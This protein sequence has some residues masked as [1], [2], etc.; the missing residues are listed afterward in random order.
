MPLQSTFGGGAA[1]IYRGSRFGNANLTINYSS[2]AGGGGGSFTGYGIVGYGAGGAGGLIQ[3]T[4]ITIRSFIYVII[5]AGG[6]Q[7]ASGSNTLMYNGY[8]FYVLAKGGGGANG[9][10][11]GSGGGAGGYSGATPGL[12]T[13]GQGNNG[14]ALAGTNPEYGGSG[15]GGAGAVGGTATSGSTSSGGA[16]GNGLACSATDNIVRAGG[17]GGWSWNSGTNLFTKANGGTGGG[18]NGGYDSINPLIP[19][20]NGATNTGGGGGG[21]VT[22]NPGGSGGSGIVVIRYTSA[23]VLARGGTITQSGGNVFHTFTSSGVFSTIS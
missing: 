20:T 7:L 16:G 14:G 15:G 10:S 19:P 21:A 17:G 3:G 22:G 5:G 12:G 9:Q 6:T 2:V 11:G 13:A 23:T 1:R 8:G 4:N 18:G